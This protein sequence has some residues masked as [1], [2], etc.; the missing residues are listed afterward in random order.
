MWDVWPWQPSACAHW[1][2]WH[3]FSIDKLQTSCPVGKSLR[4]IL[5]IVSS[6]ACAHWVPKRLA[7]IHHAKTSPG[8]YQSA[9][10]LLAYVQHSELLVKT[11]TDVVMFNTLC[12]LSST[13]TDFAGVVVIQHVKCHVSRHFFVL[14]KQRFWCAQVPKN[15]CNPVYIVQ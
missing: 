11:K 8:W 2:V 10:F 9:A 6:A 3:F 14:S 12:S 7:S 1:T 13:D 4:L 5:L 15:V